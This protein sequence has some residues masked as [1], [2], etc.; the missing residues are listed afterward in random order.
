MT[1][2]DAPTVFIIDDD[3]RMRAAMQRL[4]KSI[5]LLIEES[6]RTTHV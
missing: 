6:F 4:L 2:S 1:S 5:G 3:D